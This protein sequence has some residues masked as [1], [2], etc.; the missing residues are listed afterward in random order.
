MVG[1]FK[2][3]RCRS[4]N[5]MTSHA[6]ILR[7]PDFERENIPDDDVTLEK[8]SSVVRALSKKG[9]W[10]GIVYSHFSGLDAGRI[11]QQEMAYFHGLNQA[12]EWKVYSHD[13]PRDLLA[14]L[15]EYDFQ[16]GH[17]EA[18]LIFDLL[19]PPNERL[20]LASTKVVVKR[21]SDQPGVE[22]YLSVEATVWG[23]THSSQSYLLETFKD[24]LSPNAA[25]VAY[26]ADQPT[27][28]GRITISGQSHFV[29]LWGGS[30]LSE[31]RGRGVYRALLSARIRQAKRIA[32]VRYLRVDALPSSQP[33]LEK[34]GFRRLGSTWPANSPQVAH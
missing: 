16:I 32:S 27:G 7:R 12:F 30:V 8:T 13:D 33:I 6:T 17:E 3:Q 19:E 21:V 11:I 2:G 4:N 15:R 34:Y 28:I 23:E 14:R 20:P 18:L 29:G 9:N 31:F 1:V 10:Y 25:F 24:P 22:D 26:A 5:L